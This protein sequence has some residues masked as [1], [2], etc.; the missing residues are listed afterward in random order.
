MLYAWATPKRRREEIDTT[1]LT[2]EST[3]RAVDEPTRE[4]K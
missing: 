3:K 2:D 4:E 1:R